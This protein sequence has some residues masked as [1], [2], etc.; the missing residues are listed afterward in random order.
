MVL[1]NI[2]YTFLDWKISQ[3]KRSFLFLFIVSILLFQFSWQA[4]TTCNKTVSQIFI[5]EGIWGHLDLSKGGG[6]AGPDIWCFVSIF[7]NLLRWANR[8]VSWPAQIPVGYMTRCQR[9]AH[10]KR[11]GITS[12]LCR[13]GGAFDP[14][15]ISEMTTY[16]FTLFLLKK[17]P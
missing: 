6:T 16:A 17:F 7:C 13:G 15:D 8:F 9:H 3:L 2:Y 1:L 12:D 14:Q 4:R 10:T 5:P 11:Y